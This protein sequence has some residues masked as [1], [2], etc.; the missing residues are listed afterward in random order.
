MECC[1]HDDEDHSPN[2]C[3]VIIKAYPDGGIV[4]CPCHKARISGFTEPFPGA[5]DDYAQYLADQSVS[6]TFETEG[7]N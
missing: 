2:G 1:G 4:I 3:T 5:N 6:N 7:G